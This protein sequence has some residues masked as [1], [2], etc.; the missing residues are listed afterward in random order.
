M[1]NGIRL[2]SDMIKIFTLTYG[3]A[4]ISVIS[5]GIY[6]VI[7]QRVTVWRDDESSY[8]F[9]R[10]LSIVK[11]SVTRSFS[12]FYFHRLIPRESKQFTGNEAKMFGW[13]Y[14]I[15]GLFM[16]TP[17]IWAHYALKIKITDYFSFLIIPQ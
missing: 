9:S 16:L 11:T 2:A 8:G 10:G 13:I 4:S 12:P 7:S 17:L 1:E 3:V 5:Y 14:I 6:S 15:V